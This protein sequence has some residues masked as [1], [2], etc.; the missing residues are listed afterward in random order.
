MEGRRANT[1][2]RHAEARSYAE[3]V[4]ALVEPQVGGPRS[5]RSSPALCNALRLQCL[6][7]ANLG[8]LADAYTI[9]LRLVDA[10]EKQFGAESNDVAEV[11]D[12]FGRLTSVPPSPYTLL[13]VILWRVLT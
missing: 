7:L 5:G 13:F 4:L 12:D 3:K 9:S 2:A 8:F 11:L 6:A 1:A 10:T